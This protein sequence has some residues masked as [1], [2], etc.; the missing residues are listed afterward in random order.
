MVHEDFM[1]KKKTIGLFIGQISDRYHSKI[2][3]AVLDTAVKNEMNLIIFAGQSINEPIGFRSQE[4]I[5]YSFAGKENIDGLLIVAGSIGNYLSDQEMSEFI[6]NYKS[7]PIV[8]IAR[9]IEGIPNVTVE[10]YQGMYDLVNHMIT[11]HGREKIAFIRGPEQ[12]PEAESRFKAYHDALKKNGI[13]YDESLVALGTFAGPTGAAGVIELLDVRKVYFDCLVAANDDMLLWALKVLKERNIKIPEEVSIGGF[14]NLIESQYSE[15]PITTVEQPLVLLAR[16]AAEVLIDLIEGK[17][18]EKKDHA[19]AA[20]VVIR[21]SCGCFSNISRKES[22]VQVQRKVVMTDEQIFSQLE[23]KKKEIY[24]K[25]IVNLSFPD[26]EKEILEYNVNNLLDAF[27][28]D[29]NHKESPN[30]ME[31]VTYEIIKPLQAK[32][33]MEF[34]SSIVFRI[35]NIVQHYID[36]NSTLFINSN[37]IFE[38]VQNSISEQ[39]KFLFNIESGNFWNLLWD[40]KRIT[41]NLSGTFEIEKIKDILVKECPMTGIQA[42]NISLYENSVLKPARFYELVSKRSRMIFAYNQFEKV[43]DRYIDTYYDT[44]KIVPYD[45]FGTSPI[46]CLVIYPLY[47][48]KTHFGFVSFELHA[49]A[50]YPI[51]DSV[52]EHISS[53]LQ[54]AFLIQELQNTQ[55]QLIESVKVAKEANFHKSKVLVNMSHELRTPLNSINGV[56]GLLQAGGY[57][58]TEEVVI[59]IQELIRI[60]EA[61]KNAYPELTELKKELQNYLE[62]IENF[63]DLKPYFFIYFNNKIKQRFG[64]EYPEISEKLNQIINY[65]KEEDDETVKAYQHIKEAGSYLLELI[66]TVLNLSKVE[67]GKMEVFRTKVSIRTLIESAIVDSENYAR[68]INKDALIKFENEI[69]KDVPENCFM[70]KQKVKEVLLNLISNGIKYTSRGTIKIKVQIEGQYIKVMVSDTGMGIRNEEK[71]KIFTEFG[72]TNEA[73][74]I[75]GTGLGLV[76]SKRLIE[77]QDGRIGFDSVYGKGSTFWFTI[78]V[79]HKL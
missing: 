4:N 14:D 45:I 19:V 74:K 71:D 49:H 58:K 21:K 12:N 20:S 43:P 27:L 47:F 25:C 5:I 16:K 64:K 30:N 40:M 75:E 31:Q 63:A 22:K 46:Q 7:I 11:E 72:R 32:E 61:D 42:S 38:K 57:E 6:N 24:Q 55:N 77:M 26:Y 66:D 67:S 65:L 3:P 18:S 28:K 29:L 15:P 78:P 10:N 1:R 60:I 73:K 13:P 35:Q 48:Q 37:Y 68:S 62:M 53:A 50:L 41:D 59:I 34:W 9:K 33:L 79:Q 70:D 17:E 36:K 56:A 44:K 54:G 69:Q 39:I 51:Q 23:E 76:W 2:W 8:N 52:K